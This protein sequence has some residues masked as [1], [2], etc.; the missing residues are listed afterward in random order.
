[1][2]TISKTVFLLDTWD[3]SVTLQRF[4]TTNYI[5]GEGTLFIL[6]KY[7]YLFIL[8]STELTMSLLVRKATKSIIYNNNEIHVNISTS[9]SGLLA[10]IK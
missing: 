5:L 2:G 4:H 7:F 6:H 10:I 9:N 8:V 1:M 3:I